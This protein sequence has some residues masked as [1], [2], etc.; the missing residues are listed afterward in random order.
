MQQQRESA[1]S[2]VDRFAF[3]GMAPAAQDRNFRLISAFSAPMQAS[4]NV[5]E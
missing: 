1:L 2:G 3:P 5:A 4:H